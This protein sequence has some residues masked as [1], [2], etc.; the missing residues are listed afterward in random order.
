MS[1]INVSV[2]AVQTVVRQGENITVMCIVTGNE[3]VNFEWTYPRLEVPPGRAGGGRRRGGRGNVEPG[4]S[5]LSRLGLY[6]PTCPCRLGG[7]WSQ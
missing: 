2:G 3:V 7:W 4:F 1:S 5:G 6:P